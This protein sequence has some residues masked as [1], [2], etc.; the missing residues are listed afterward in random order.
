MFGYVA[1]GVFCGMLGALFSTVVG[2]IIYL[3][4]KI[5]LAVISS[6]WGYCLLV[7]FVTALCSF[8]I[9]FLQSTDRQNL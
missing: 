1:L 9:L 6:R 7:A 3:R 4:K 8:P 5:E 2:K